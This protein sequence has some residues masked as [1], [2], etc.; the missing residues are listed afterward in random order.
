M[1]PNLK[2]K[3]QS[4]LQTLKT[5][6]ACAYFADDVTEAKRDEIEQS[7]KLSIAAYLLALF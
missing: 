4:E 3:T 6:L 7:C 5:E 2:D 1:L